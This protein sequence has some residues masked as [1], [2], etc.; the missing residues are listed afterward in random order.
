MNFLR[1]LFKM[2]PVVRLTTQWPERPVDWT[3]TM[4]DL[5]ERILFLSEHGRSK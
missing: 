1:R 2:K 3:F 4:S 5:M